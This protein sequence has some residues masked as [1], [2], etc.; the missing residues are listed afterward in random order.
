MKSVNR[1]LVLGLSTCAL[2]VMGATAWGSPLSGVAATPMPL[3]QTPQTPQP[4]QTQQMP[5]KS[6]SFTG[7]V[8]KEGDQY[9]LRDSSGEVYKLDDSTKAQQFEGKQVKVTG[10]LDA[11]AKMIHVDSIE[12]AGA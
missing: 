11:D 9:V 2:L 7:T 12:G 6:A 10:R 8:V 4:D 5:A 3:I 1:S